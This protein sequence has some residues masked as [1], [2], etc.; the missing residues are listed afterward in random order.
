MERT[1]D[2]SWI[3]IFPFTISTLGPAPTATAEVV[4]GTA[5]DDDDEEEEEERGA[6]NG[7][8]GVFCLEVKVLSESSA[9]LF[10]DF[11]LTN[12]RSQSCDIVRLPLANSGATTGAT[13]GTGT[14][15]AASLLGFPI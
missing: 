9:F 12:E 13:T 7:L 14:A 5:T 15:T 1:R 6:P 8:P 10:P 4:E 2:S 3:T 11:F